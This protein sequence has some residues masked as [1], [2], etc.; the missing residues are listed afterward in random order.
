MH[1]FNHRKV[2]I[3]EGANDKERLERIISESIDIVCT[4]G[5]FGIEKFDIML[6]KYDLDNRD[7]FI[8]VDEDDAG[9]ELRE[10]LTAELPHATQLYIDPQYT[11]V[12]S[13]P[14]HLLA[15]ELRAHF[16]KVHPTF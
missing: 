8:F 15:D 6:D 10:Q 11:E 13:T 3:V 16:I 12:E 5:T 9:K 4:F 7:V 2:I 14:K 1:H